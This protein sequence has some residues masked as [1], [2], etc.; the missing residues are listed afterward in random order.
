MDL[1]FRLEDVD[2]DLI[3]IADFMGMNLFIEFCEKFGGE[4]LY[5]PCKN[6]ILRPSRNR[7]IEKLYNGYNHKY[8]AREFGISVTQVKNILKNAKRN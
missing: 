6:S 3:A 8:L 1:D 5:F 4:R 2:E 7:Q